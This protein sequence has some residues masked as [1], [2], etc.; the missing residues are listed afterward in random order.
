MNTAGLNTG[1]TAILSG[2]TTVTVTVTVTV[3]SA[4]ANNQCPAGSVAALVTSGTLPLGLSG[5]A[6]CVS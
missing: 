6:V 3:S 1:I 2:G 5:T 4:G